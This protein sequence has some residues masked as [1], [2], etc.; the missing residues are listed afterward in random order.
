MSDWKSL[1]K[2]IA[3]TLATVLG[4]PLAGAAVSA[5]S[6]SLLGKSDGT[7]DE[8][9]TAMA[10]GSPEVLAKVIEAEKQFKLDMKRLDIDYEKVMSDDRSSARQRETQTQD[11]TVR[12]L[13]YV[14]TVGYFVTLFGLW[15]FGMPDDIKGE[16]TLLLG[17]LT[18][19]QAA[20]MNYYFGSSAS[21][22]SKDETIKAQAMSS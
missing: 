18:A 14:Y 22:R 4:G 7:T 16:M 13:A 17:V 20:I 6:A 10:S 15:K 19:A 9:E 2:T 21:S 8:V 12:R 5:L 11:P 3:P 1:V